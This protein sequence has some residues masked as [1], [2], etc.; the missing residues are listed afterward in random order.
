MDIDTAD[1]SR[2]EGQAPIEARMVSAAAPHASPDSSASGTVKAG[3]EDAIDRRKD[4]R[5]QDTPLDPEKAG[6]QSEDAEPGEPSPSS[7]KQGQTQHGRSAL[8]DLQASAYNITDFNLRQKWWQI[9]RSRYPPPE[10]PASLDDAKILPLASA[11]FLSELLY[12]WISPIIKL[13]TKRPLQVSSFLIQE[14]H[15]GWNK[16]IANC[17]SYQAT[18]LWKMDEKRTASA[19]ATKFQKAYAHRQAAAREYNKK[20]ESGLISPSMLRRALWRLTKGSVEKKRERWLSKKTRR[21]SLVWALSETGGLFFWMGGVSKVVGDMSQLCSPLVSK[22]LIQFAQSRAAAKAAN[23]ALP[24][25]GRGIG[26]A[27]GLTILIMMGSIFQHFFF[28]RAYV[29]AVSE[30][31]VLLVF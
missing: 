3:T 21:A 29:C 5:I 19:L 2:E 15:R 1:E 11:N 31:L 4:V 23:E 26:D 14:Q 6:K 30:G 28:Y 24:G 7:N 8:G 9:H 12:I 22:N 27:F 10:P 17:R 20:L 25:I 18:D 13:G 16:Y